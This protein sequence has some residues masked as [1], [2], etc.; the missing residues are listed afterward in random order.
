M[1]ALTDYY[2]NKVTGNY[3][4]SG[5]FENANAV[6]ALDERLAELGYGNS[7][8]DAYFLGN[9]NQLVQTL[10]SLYPGFY[11]TITSQM[12]NVF[13]TQGEQRDK[14]VAKLD[15][16]VESFYEKTA[17]RIY[18][19]ENTDSYNRQEPNSRNTA[20]NNGDVSRVESIVTLLDNKYGGR[21]VWNRIRT[22]SKCNNWRLW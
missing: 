3:V 2:A 4:K 20:Q 18:G 7:F 11:N 5:Y 13:N 16:Y 1:E 10:D 17:S 9:V 6:E 8:A 15:K 22:S 19:K 14:E 21:K 12:N